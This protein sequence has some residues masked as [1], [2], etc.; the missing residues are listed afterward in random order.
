MEGDPSAPVVIV[1]FS[2]F[3]CPYCKRWYD[4][5]LPSIRAR[6]GTDV[7]IAFLH[8]PLTGIHPNAAAAHAAA[9]CAGTQGAFK[10]MH[11][12]L[13]ERQDEWSRLP[14]VG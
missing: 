12:L 8:F 7:A 5:A 13:F 2:D 4:E 9:E 1:E 6:V 14:D 3:E 11:D 10:E